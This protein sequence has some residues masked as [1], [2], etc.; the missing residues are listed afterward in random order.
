MRTS[1]IKSTLLNVNLNALLGPAEL[2]F[3]RVQVAFKRYID[4]VK[5]CV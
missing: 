4:W 1:V 3:K 2:G 5:V